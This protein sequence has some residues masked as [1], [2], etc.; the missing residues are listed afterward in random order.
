MASYMPFFVKRFH[1]MRY[2]SKPPV[3]WLKDASISGYSTPLH[4][5]FSVL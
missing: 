3:L 1:M 2:S 5:F 4:F